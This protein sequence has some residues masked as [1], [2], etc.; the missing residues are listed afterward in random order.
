MPPNCKKKHRYTEAAL[1]SAIADV[2]SGNY[3]TED[4]AKQRG[5]PTTTIWNRIHCRE[6]FHT[7]HEHEQAL[8]WAEE[9]EI[10]HWCHEI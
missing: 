6:D 3:S 9:F 2:K 1:Q 4:A 8:S 7:A 10:V 5:V